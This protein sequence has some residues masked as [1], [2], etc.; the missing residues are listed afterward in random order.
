VETA[1]CDGA[2]GSFF[3]RAFGEWQNARRRVLALADRVTRTLTAG[4]PCLVLGMLEV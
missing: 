1:V 3:D 4:R 2:P